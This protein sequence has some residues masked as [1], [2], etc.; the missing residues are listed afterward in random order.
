MHYALYHTATEKDSPR[1]GRA[2]GLARAYV[3]TSDGIGLSD[4]YESRENDYTTIGDK[5]I[6]TPPHALFTC[7]PIYTEIRRG[8]HPAG[9]KV[10]DGTR[11]ARFSR[12]VFLSLVLFYWT[13]S[14]GC[15]T[16][17]ILLSFPF[18]HAWKINFFDKGKE[19]N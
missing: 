12:L 9:D 15:R 17:I 2:V 14:K 6:I 4:S 11:H 10:Q 5:K 3:Q 7:L 8:F 19:R 13:N 18:L 16:P 1:T